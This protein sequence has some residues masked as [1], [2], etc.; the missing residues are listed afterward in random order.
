M[1]N[2]IYVY[3]SETGRIDYTIEDARQAHI[4]SFQE[5]GKDFYFGAAGGKI[6]GTYVKKNPDTGEPLGIS[7]IE[8]MTFINIDKHEINS[9][10]VDE[11]VISGLRKG[12]HVDINHEHSYVVDDESGSTLEISC[13]NYSYISEHNQMTIYFKAYGCHDSKITI[14]VLE[15]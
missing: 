12:M 13:N 8:H 5:K 10:G 6:A 7:P 4:N 9:D 14:N 1:S 11:A 15:G 3:D 2:T